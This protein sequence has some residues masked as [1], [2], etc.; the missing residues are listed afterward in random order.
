MYKFLCGPVLSFLLHISLGGKLLDHTG[1]LFTVW[2]TV[3]LFSKGAAQK[4]FHPKESCFFYLR[5]L[6]APS[7]WIFFSTTSNFLPSFLPSLLPSF[8]S[9]LLPS[10]LSFF[11][12]GPYLQHMEVPRLGVELELLQLLVYAT[13]TAMQGPSRICHLQHSSWQYQILNPLSEPRD[14]TRILMDASWVH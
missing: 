4:E 6:L 11:S 5:I 3:R 2:G 13:T 12:L 10:F 1:S 7:E 14:Q 8:P 9:S